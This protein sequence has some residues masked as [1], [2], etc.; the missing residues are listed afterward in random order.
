MSISIPSLVLLAILGL[1]W[2]TTFFQTPQLEVKPRVVEMKAPAYPAIAYLAHASGTVVIEVEINSAGDVVTARVVQ[3]HPLLSGVSRQ[4]A[5]AW[6]FEPNP[7]PNRTTGLK[8]EL[9]FDFVASDSTAIATGQ[10]KCRDGYSLVDPY[11]LKI[12]GYAKASPSSDTEND[13]PE[14]L[15]GTFCKVHHERLRKDKVEISYGLVGFKTGYLKAEERS[16]PNANSV[17]HGGCIV[18]TQIDPCSGTE[19]QLSPKYAEI[20]YCPA[21]RRAQAHWSKAHPWPKS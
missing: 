9:L 6:R 15:E 1:V 10:N 19:V 11:R 12:Y 13:I 2:P 4:A 7:N 17:M 16:F 21:C 8:T 14:N 20:L 5:L 3:G 18:E